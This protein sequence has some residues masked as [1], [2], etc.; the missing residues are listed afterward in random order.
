MANAVP[1]AA[2]SFGKAASQP[3]GR[4]PLP[5]CASGRGGP[6]VRACGGHGASPRQGPCR[7]LRPK[8]L[9][10]I[11]SGP[12]PGQPGRRALKRGRWISRLRVLARPPPVGWGRHPASSGPRASSATQCMCLTCTLLPFPEA[13]PARSPPDRFFPHPGGIV[14]RRGLRLSGSTCPERLQR[15]E[16]RRQPDSPTPPDRSRLLSAR[17]VR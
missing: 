15:V 3:P 17:L 6:P 8:Q 14:A 4:V 13:L 12:R 9:P 1:L 7:N 11:E 10:R 16:I 2:L 5:I